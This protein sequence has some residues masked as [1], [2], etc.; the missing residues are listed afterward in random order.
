MVT[1]KTK[2]YSNVA[3]LAKVVGISGIGVAA[4][5][6]VGDI[7]LSL[8]GVPLT[9]VGVA[10]A[11]AFISIAYGTPESSRQRM[12]LRA[13]ANAFL[14]IVLVAILPPMF[15]WDWVDAR[16]E[17]P[18]AG[19]TSIALKYIIPMIPEIIK[20]WLRLEKYDET[21]SN[22]SNNY[23]NGERVNYERYYGEEGE[24]AHDKQKRKRTPHGK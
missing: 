16:L 7:S 19:V 10:T 15:G 21:Y 20:K 24:E 22:G 3:T 11:G 6:S 18:L 5:P 13:F 14:S 23:G 4:L 2:G 1:R 8:F 9:V 12:F 17:P